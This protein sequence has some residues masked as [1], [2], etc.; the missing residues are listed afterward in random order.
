MAIKILLH[1]S[2]DSIPARTVKVFC[3]SL[4]SATNNQQKQVELKTTPNKSQ[5]QEKAKVKTAPKRH[6]LEKVKFKTPP[7]DVK[8]KQEI[9]GFVAQ[10]EIP[11][12]IHFTR[13]CNVSSILKHGLLPRKE[14]RKRLGRQFKLV[15][16][17]DQQRYDQHLDANCLSISYPNYRMFFRYQTANPESYW[18]VIHIRTDILW[19]MDCAFCITNAASNCIRSRPIEELKTASALAALF[20]DFESG[21]DGVTRSSLPIPNCFPTNP[22]AEVLVFETIPASDV[23]AI[24]LKEQDELSTKLTDSWSDVPVKFSRAFFGPRVDFEHWQNQSA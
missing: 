3:T 13:A 21:S 10:R 19:K 24:Y 22:Q 11:Y 17:N 14:L 12:L 7:V 4:S 20:N 16:I 2:L 5:K 23:M 1:S 18:A 15:E 6:K 9:Q 8:R